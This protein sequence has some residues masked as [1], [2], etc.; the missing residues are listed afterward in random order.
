MNLTCTSAAVS[1]S[2]T[3]VASGKLL[4]T[5]PSQDPATFYSAASILGNDPAP[6]GTLSGT[7]KIKWTAPVNQKFSDKKSAITINSVVGGVTAIGADIYGSFAIPG[8]TPG[9]T[10]GAFGGTDSGASTTQFVPTAQDETALTA[11]ATS[12]AGIATIALGNGTA[13]LQ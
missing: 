1:G 13:T 6:G 10:A 12:A 8:T 3:G 4:S 7:L 2:F 11:E 9:S 5:N